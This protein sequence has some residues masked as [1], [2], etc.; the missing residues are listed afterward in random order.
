MFV[1]AHQHF[2]SIARGD[3]GW[4]TA[5]SGPIYRDFLPAD[6]APH[7]RR[8][9]IAKTVLVQ[10]APTTEET[11][12]LLRLADE[13]AWVGAVVGW[14]D[15]ERPDHLSHLKRWSRNPKFRAV[16]PMIQDL[17]DPAWVL[18]PALDWA[19][20]ALQDLD[21]H[22]EFLGLPAHLDAA[23]ALLKRYPRLTVVLDHGMKPQVRN[24]AFEPWAT[25]IDAIARTTRACC[26]LSG[27][28]TEAL[29][30]WDASDIKLYADHLLQAF[31][32]DRL[33]WGSD[34]PV[35]NLNGG[36]DAWR[37]AT[38]EL[39]GGCAGSDQILGGTACR[40]YRLC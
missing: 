19:F 27:L 9:G 14:V 17:P 2:W 8:H 39:I 30:G 10:A 37:N 18:D 5:K 29:P 40:V 13:T 35:V 12:Y 6:L 1:D 36:F 4:L 31:G 34:W 28:V 32:P 33:M 7:L 24:R 20:R 23:S 38:L 15:F 3:Y 21:L 11:D 25:G 26:K 22:F 16:R